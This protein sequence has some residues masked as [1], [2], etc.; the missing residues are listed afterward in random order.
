MHHERDAVL[1]GSAATDIV[2]LTV[3]LYTR[4][5]FSFTFIEISD[6]KCHSENGRTCMTDTKTQ[7]ENIASHP[8]W[9][10]RKTKENL[11]LEL[12]LPVFAQPSSL[13]RVSG[14]RSSIRQSFG[15]SKNKS[16]SKRSNSTE[17]RRI[18]YSFASLQLFG[19]SLLWVNL[20]WKYT[21]PLL[22]TIFLIVIK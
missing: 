22:H 8:V 19:I 9:N 6:V 15:A 1:V 16:F 5:V 10:K 21:Y 2:S 20:Y 14:L 4:I 12:C 11:K 3:Y 18:L 13:P 17:R 7:S